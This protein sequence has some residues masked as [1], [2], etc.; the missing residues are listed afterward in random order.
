M[1]FPLRKRPAASYHERPRSFGSPRGDTRK[2]A[3]CDL[4]APAETEV[5]AVE[6]GTVI[7]GP[8]LFYDV[9]YALEVQHLSG[10]VRY[11]EISR[12]AEG[13][14]VGSPVKAGQVIAYVGKMKSVAQSMLH[15][16]MFHGLTAGES[17]GP[18]TDRTRTPFMRRADLMDPTGPLDAAELAVEAT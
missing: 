13:I 11:G 9:V 5:L 4:Y 15:F 6:D 17:G 7:R 8:Y 10:I 2:H 12:A 18:L 3:G 16:E 1:L 14:K